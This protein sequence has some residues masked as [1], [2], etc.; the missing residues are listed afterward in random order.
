MGDKFHIV[1]I[2][3]LHFNSHESIV[4]HGIKFVNDL[5]VVQR[6]M[7]WRGGSLDPDLPPGK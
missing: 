7:D 2:I 6:Q 4:M 3:S 1:K 5:L